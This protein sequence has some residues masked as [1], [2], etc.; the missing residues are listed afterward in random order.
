MEMEM[1][2]RVRKNERTQKQF[3]KW[4]GPKNNKS[5]ANEYEWWIESTE[6]SSLLLLF[7]AGLCENRSKRASHQSCIYVF[8]LQW[9]MLACNMCVVRAVC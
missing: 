5:N 9:V 4:N 6:S 8:D 7:R 3:K 2:M 1:L